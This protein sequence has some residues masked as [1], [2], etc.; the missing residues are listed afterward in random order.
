MRLTAY[1]SLAVWARRPEATAKWLSRWLEPRRPSA[2][3]VC[4]LKYI[5]IQIRRPATGPTCF[6]STNFLPY[7][8]ASWPFAKP[9]RVFL[10]RRQEFATHCTVLSATGSAVPRGG[11]HRADG[12]YANDPNTCDDKPRRSRLAIGARFPSQIGRRQ[13]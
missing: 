2:S 11:L 8:I 7:S 5:R 10:D 6:A 4:S 9:W 12:A 3:M 13:R 1:K